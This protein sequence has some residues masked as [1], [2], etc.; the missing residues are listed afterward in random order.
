VSE[1]LNAL[2]LGLVE[3][4]TEFLPISS[5]GHLILA[6]AL[7]GFADERAGV[8]FV[9]IQTGAMLAVV[10]EYRARFFRID[11][12]LYKNLAVAFVPAAILGL[13]FAKY[14][15]S[16]L[17]H[18]VPVA[19][20]F[21]VGGVVILYV[22]RRTLRP[23][24]DATGAMTW[25]DAL[26]VGIAQCFAL[27]PG[28]SRAGATIIGGMLFGLSRPAAT[29]FSFFLAVPTL[30]AAGGY[31]LWK[32]RALFSADDLGMF[33]VGLLVSFLSAFVVIRWLIRY[34]ATHDFRPF[35]WYRI[36][37]GAVVLV[38]AYAGWVDWK[39]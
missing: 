19:L 3:G 28:T 12:S 38:T 27:I 22:E 4:A 21:I 7:L 37:F 34:V 20:A 1:L 39:S 23:R 26:K 13:L 31:D 16:Y 18:A 2:V 24:V 6:G 33:A 10:W 30:V 5:T 25:L 14:I 35:A 36:A 9:A 11:L 29:E 15:K 32:H 17:F 8:F